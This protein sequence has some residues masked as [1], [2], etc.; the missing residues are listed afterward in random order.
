MMRMRAVTLLLILGLGLLCSAASA[1]EA[2]PAAPDAPLVETGQVRGRVFDAVS[3]AALEGATVT[4]VWPPQEGGG[5]PR[6]EARSTDANGEFDFGPIPTGSYSVRYHKPGYRPSTMTSF[7]VQAGRE[8]RADFPLPRAAERAEEPGESPG[9]EEFV[10]IASPL[11]EILAASRLESDE[12]LN[13]MSA[14]EISKFAASDVADA[15]KFVPGVNVVE[16]QFAIIR[17]L[18]DRY[19]STLYNSAPI[20]SPDPD[21][22]SVQLDLFPSEIVTNLAVSKTFGAD[23]PSNSS[24]GSINIISHEYPE[25]VS[26][27]LSAGVGANDNALDGFLERHDG[28]P[29]GEE[30]D[31]SDLIEDEFGIAFSGRTDV[32]PRELRFKALW[33]QDVDYDT[34]EGFQEGRE[35][36]RSVFRNFPAPPRVIEPGDLSPGDLSLSDG[37]YD[38]TESESTEQS[39]S[40]LGLGF[41]LDGEGGHRIDLSSFLVR[42]DNDVVQLGAN[43][44]LPGQDYARLLELQTEG[45]EILESEFEDAATTGSPLRNVRTRPEGAL[46]E[47]PVWFAA[48]SNSKSFDRDRSLDV[49]QI[50]GDHRPSPLE[51]LHVSWAANHARTQE[52]EGAFGARFF[53]EPLD[54]TDADVVP[55]RAPST[56]EAL[57]DGTYFATADIFSNENDI[58]ETQN[59]GRLDAEY[60]AQLTDALELVVSTGGWRERADRDV[61]SSFLETPTVGGSGV[62]VL[63]GNTLDAAGKAISP[64]LNRLEGGLYAGSRVSTNDSLREIQAVSFGGKATLFEVVDLLAGVRLESLRIESNNDPFVTGELD[65]DGTPRIFPS[66]YAFLDRND[67]PARDPVTARPPGTPWN[68]QLLNL[69]LQVDPNT[70]FVDLVDREDIEAV[71]DGEIDESRTLPAY[72]IAYRPIEGLSLR[73]AFSRT[74]ARPSFRE[75]G[76]YVSVEPATDDLVI[77]N[78]QLQLSDVKSWDARAEYAW[79]DLGDLAAV[80]VFT[81]RIEKPIESIVVRDQVNFEGSTSALYRTFFNNP[82]EARVEGIE[83]EA[84]K[85]LD[86][87]GVE[88]LQYFSL[89]GN[90]T[91][92][93]AEVGRTAAELSRSTAFF[94]T[95]EGTP[96]RFGRLDDERRLFGQP[97]YIANADVTFSHPDWGTKITLAYFQISDILDAAGTANLNADGRVQSFTLDRYIDAYDQLDLVMSQKVHVEA[98]GGDLVLKASAKNLTDSKRQI[99]YDPEQTAHTIV[100]RSLRIGRDFSF[101]IGY[102]VP[103]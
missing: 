49:Y 85:S 44:F 5:E 92:I 58:D 33:N 64:S 27:K 29:V 59:F 15:L 78:P 103:F 91:Y 34:G 16:G 38:L 10:V 53:Y 8:N 11:E 12:L 84:R 14:E 77:G 93:S 2:R 37:R 70:G 54:P 71:I 24:G 62:F 35:P 86:F 18:E 21:S 28:T 73:G 94:G 30:V 4:L 1:Q 82:N 22:Q 102:D 75:M 72:S 17:G 90:Y 50:N 55:E 80:S 19:S 39:M 68:D 57:G 88:F 89:G 26:L 32:G 96:A 100:E 81:K 56:P 52:D 51:G 45:Q 13:T 65:L 42:K 40:Y 67:N 69:R 31:G 87:F 66:K 25:E 79:G 74:V 97:E 101:S 3:E 60:E 36:A 98:L 9:V 95:P 76:Y 23:L 20:P 7:V 48:F 47:G 46:T 83:L 41:D 61:R 43:G 99:I 63:P 6:T